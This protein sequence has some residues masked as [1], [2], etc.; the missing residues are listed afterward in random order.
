MEARLIIYSLVVGTV[1]HQSLFL[2][3]MPL[4]LVSMEVE[5]E[6]QRR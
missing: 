5:T 1:L 4:P 3:G 6:T 2:L